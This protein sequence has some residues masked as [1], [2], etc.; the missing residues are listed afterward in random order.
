MPYKD[1]TQR[2]AYSADYNRRF[3][4]DNSDSEKQRVYTRRGEIKAWFLEH[5]T[6]LA[7][8]RC[9]EDHPACIDFH[10]RDPGQKVEK[11][12]D[13]VRNGWGIQ[14][15]KDELNKCDPVCANCHRKLHWG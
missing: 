2:L 5:R 1:R 12:T 9:G 6:S 11:V 3:Y 7:C 8:I 14:R 15:I 4:A 10:H 13:M